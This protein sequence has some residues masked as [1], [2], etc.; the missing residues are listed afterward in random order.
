MTDFEMVIDY[1]FNNNASILGNII[2]KYSPI[3]KKAM[4]R[5]YNS[6]HRQDFYQDAA[7]SIIELLN[8]LEPAKIA[9]PDNFTLGF[10]IKQRVRNVL[11]KEISKTMDQ[12][13]YES[14]ESYETL[15]ENHSTDNGEYANAQLRNTEKL[16]TYSPE[17]YL[18][19]EKYMHNANTSVK[20]A[21]EILK[22]DNVKKEIIKLIIFQKKSRKEVSQT[23]NMDIRKIGH[24]VFRFKHVLQQI[25]NKE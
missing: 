13:I 11:S 19:A 1:K 9:N 3:I 23:V 18:K 25:E 12:N 22:Y 2:K 10:V 4:G 6:S 14:R 7:L 20:R 15:I 16:H 8:W 24:I 21:F 17:S 5:I